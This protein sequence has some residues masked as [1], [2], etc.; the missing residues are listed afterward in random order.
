MVK[1]K[2]KISGGFRTD[3][4]A[5]QFASIRGFIST[6]R[7]QGCRILDAIARALSG[8]FLFPCAEYTA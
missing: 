4:G 3:V 5:K 8:E 7:K 6:A 1:T 2:V